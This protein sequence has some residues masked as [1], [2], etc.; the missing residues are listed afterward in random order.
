MFNTT[1]STTL[2][3]GLTREPSANDTGAGYS[4]DAFLP[5]FVVMTDCLWCSWSMAHTHTRTSTLTLCPAP[6]CHRFCSIVCACANEWR[7]RHK[8]QNIV[9]CVSS[10]KSMSFGPQLEESRVECIIRLGRVVPRQVP[11]N[12]TYV[13]SHPLLSVFWYSLQNVLQILYLVQ[14]TMPIV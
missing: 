14:K 9:R 12:M 3:T 2:Y 8:L 4:L 13:W 10:P 11:V 1:H 6:N 7:A 5:F